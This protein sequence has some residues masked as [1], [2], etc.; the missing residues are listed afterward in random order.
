MKYLDFLKNKYELIF[1]YLDSLTFGCTYQYFYKFKYFILYSN[2]DPDEF[3]DFFRMI[4][5]LFQL[6]AINGIRNFAYG[7]VLH[8]F[9]FF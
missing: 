9:F 5:I 3:K 6:N 8:P 1:S 7:I 2:E 4:N